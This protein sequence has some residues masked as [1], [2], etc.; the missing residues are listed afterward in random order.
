MLILQ[1]VKIEIFELQIKK[2]LKA[3]V[4]LIIKC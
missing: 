4:L 3:T 1:F 2:L